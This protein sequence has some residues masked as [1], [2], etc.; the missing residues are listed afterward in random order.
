MNFMSSLRSKD[1]VEEPMTL[2]N[3][4]VFS[5]KGYL[6]SSETLVNVDRMHLYKD[7]VDG[8]SSSF[9]PYQRNM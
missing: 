6:S 4:T 7:E 2:P 8:M 1:T 9:G 3:D 5:A